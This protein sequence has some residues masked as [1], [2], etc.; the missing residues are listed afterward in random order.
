MKNLNLYLILVF[1]CSCTGSQPIADNQILLTHPVKKTTGEV[2][3]DHFELEAI[4]PIE[5]TKD[6][7]LSG[8]NR[9]IYHKTKIIILDRSAT[10]IFVIDAN[11]GKVET[12]I[13]RKGRGP[14]ESLNILDIAFDDK[15]EQILVFN[16]YYKLLYFDLKGSFLKE[17]KITDESFDEIVYDNGKVIFYNA[18]DGYGCFPHSVSFYDLQDK[19][20]KKVGE[21]RKVDFP[22]RGYGRS[23][24]KSKNIWFTP[25]LDFGLHRL[26]DGEIEVPYKL[27]QKPLSD[28]VREKSISDIVSFY[29]EVSDRDILHSIHSIRETE[30]FIIFKS[31]RRDGFL[32][33]SKKE[34]KLFWEER[35]EDT[36]LGLE[37]MRYFPHNG[38]DNRIMF[39]VNAYEW[40]E[41]SPEDADN[42]PEQIRKKTDNVKVTEESNPIL[43]FYK[44]K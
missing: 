28:E 27:D 23:L 33:M 24:V 30:K 35:V 12:H 44:E 6:F 5:T 31:N 14:G 13:H 11:N 37:S 4:M 29:R 42:I 1:L 40:V 3:L 19:S 18:G 17:E 16:D 7:L 10:S 22:V 2:F 38:D 39:V 25:V 36:N 21:D 26:N 9:V 20:W 43:V 41:R 8:I 32:M 34:S 15:S